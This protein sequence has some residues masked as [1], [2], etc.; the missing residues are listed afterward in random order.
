MSLIVKLNDYR[1]H[2]DLAARQVNSLEM[3]LDR[4]T[5]MSLC[6]LCNGEEAS[7]TSENKILHC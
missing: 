7:Q 3:L 2:L 5:P 6:C 4:T 1:E